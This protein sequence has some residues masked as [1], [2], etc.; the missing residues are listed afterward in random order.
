MLKQRVAAGLTKRDVSG[1]M[2]EDQLA[3][4]SART[5]RMVDEQSEGIAE[6]TQQLAAQGL[7][8]S[9]G[10]GLTR[11]QDS[12]LDSY[13]A[14]E[15]LPVLTPL[16]VD[17][18][19]PFPVL[20]GLS[21]NLALL[22]RNPG[23]GDDATHIA[24]VP[25]PRNLP[26][27]ISVPSEE[28]LRLVR[29]EQVIQRRA[30]ALFPD[31]EVL[32]DAVFRLT[33]D[34]DVAI[35]DDA[36]AD[37]LHAVEDAVRARRRRAVV[38]LEVSAGADA[39][40]KHWLMDWCQVSEQDTYQ[41]E[42]LLDATALM[43]MANRPGFD[44]LR[45]PPWEPQPHPDLEGAA[46]LWEAIQNRDIF[47]FHPYDSFK[48]VVSLVELAAADP[49]VLAI[50]QTLYRTSGDSPIVAALARAAESGKQVTVLVELKARFDEARNVGWA[51]S[52]EDA[53]CHV[54][55]GVAG[56]KT[57][58]KLLLIIRREAHGI[59]RYVHAATGNYNDRTARL[60][61]DMGL[62]TTDRDFAADASAFFNLLTGYSQDVGWSQ[63]TI[64]PT[65]LRRRMVELIEREIEAS[66]LDQPGLIMVKV[67]S[68]QD[69]A[70]CR[71]LCR[72]ARGG[73]KVRLNVRGICCLRPGLEGVSENIEV[74]SIVDRYLEH[75]RVFCFRNGGHE[76]VYLS[77]ADW[78]A[79]NLDRRLETLFPV[80]D[81]ALRRRVVRIM[82]TFFADNVK[83]W[84]LRSD[85]TY[86][87]VVTA[88]PPVRA[89]EQFYRDAVE[90]ALS[91]RGA[92]MQFRPLTSPDAESG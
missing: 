8:L 73:V 14:S 75:A 91:Q 83:A 19:E 29:L 67:N 87:R 58:A 88:G 52:L 43:E 44:T 78:M 26:R 65:G 64:S 27:F 74:T 32:A 84:R 9:E 28:G 90:A 80:L 39:G 71:A 3:A 49:N 31:Q 69:P 60:Y 24:I 6:V 81:P 79:R 53:G 22:L 56:L 1:L 62:M 30:G 13:F 72:A 86:E 89:Q 55:Y 47:L 68:L 40:L 10:R 61:S 45:D 17:E 76:E 16:A 50:K 25:V 18:L 70:I 54:I 38:R 46:D 15:I 48:P 12:F 85:G 2:P 41:Q 20:P 21:L 7:D 57:H 35:D 42:G 11:Q 66:S 5:H 33:R 63:F 34:A 23:E 59:R 82:D 51:R 36:G 92:A 37:L 4:I 77:S